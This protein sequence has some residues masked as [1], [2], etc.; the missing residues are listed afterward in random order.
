MY[1]SK[2]LTLLAIGIHIA[3]M[4]TLL[5][6][7]VAAGIGAAVYAALTVKTGRASEP[8]KPA[9]LELWIDSSQFKRWLAEVKEMQYSV[10]LVAQQGGSPDTYIVSTPEGQTVVSKPGLDAIERDNKLISIKYV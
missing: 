2:I 5:P 6:G 10:E 4:E 1:L 3:L 7:I 9:T 8:P